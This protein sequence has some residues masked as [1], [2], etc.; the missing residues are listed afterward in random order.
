MSKI[1]AVDVG[2]RVFRSK[3][4]LREF[5]RKMFDFAPWGQFRSQVLSDVVALGHPS[6][7]D[8]HKPRFFI[9][10]LKHSK[11]ASVKRIARVRDDEWAWAN[12]PNDVCDPF[13]I[14]AV[15]DNKYR[16][17]AYPGPIG[18]G[19]RTYQTAKYVEVSSKRLFKAESPIAAL[20]KYLRSADS[21]THHICDLCSRFESPFHSPSHICEMCSRPSLACE[22]D[23]WP[24]THADIC[25]EILEGLSEDQIKD[26]C[27]PGL[28]NKC[29]SAKEEYSKLSL[30]RPLCRDCHAKR[31]AEALVKG[32]SLA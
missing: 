2:G 7:D 19:G 28:A 23:H 13:V 26:V 22:W 32:A 25:G 14:D 6:Y 29:Y 12:L 4:S 20:S 30:V 16:I 17:K 8:R 15:F 11:G 27:T 18:G 24:R 3:T 5:V 31:T 10:D 21:K 1:F 9:K